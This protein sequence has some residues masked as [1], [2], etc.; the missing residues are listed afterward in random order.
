MIQESDLVA[1]LS[2]FPKLNLNK[3]D[4]GTVAFCYNSGELFE[5]EFVNA[6]GETIGVETLSRVQIKKVEIENTILHVRQF[7]KV[8]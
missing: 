2:D 1:L 4:V 6:K 3:G 8:A 7:K 5:I